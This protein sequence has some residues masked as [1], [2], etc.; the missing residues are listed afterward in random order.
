MSKDQP[1][2]D[3][4]QDDLV[5]EIDGMISGNIL[6]NAPHMKALLQRARD[7]II[8]LHKDLI[9][10]NEWASAEIAALRAQL[11]KLEA[12]RIARVTQLEIGYDELNDICDRQ[13]KL[14]ID[15]RAQL[16]ERECKIPSAPN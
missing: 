15:L 13:N 5:R 6:A 10:C 11:A 3:P 9:G 2:A 12:D 8:Q 4:P 7:L 16:A 1:A 14:I